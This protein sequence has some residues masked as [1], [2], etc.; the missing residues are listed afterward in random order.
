MNPPVVTAV[1]VGHAG[2]R[3]RCDDTV[4]WDDLVTLGFVF[5]PEFVDI[6]VVV[7]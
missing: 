5:S 4:A 2:E 1:L 6:S 3:H 7:V